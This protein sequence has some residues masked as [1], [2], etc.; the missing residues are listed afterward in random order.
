MRAKLYNL[1]GDDTQY[2]DFKLL[3]IKAGLR[4]LIALPRE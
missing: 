2:D 3:I 1:A 4:I